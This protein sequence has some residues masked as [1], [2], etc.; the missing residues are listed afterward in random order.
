MNNI[1]K[2]NIKKYEPKF[3]KAVNNIFKDAYAYTRKYKDFYKTK[4]EEEKRVKE[5]AQ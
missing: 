5:I 2:F 1:I 4:N 3:Y